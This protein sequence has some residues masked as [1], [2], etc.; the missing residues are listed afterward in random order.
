MKMLNDI[1]EMKMADLQASMKEFRAQE[2]MHMA[3][4]Y[5]PPASE[6][7]NRKQRRAAK[8]QARKREMA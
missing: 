1:L 7:G 8:A 6:F 3:K 2:A 4:E 5:S